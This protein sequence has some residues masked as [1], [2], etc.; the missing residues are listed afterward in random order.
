MKRMVRRSIALAVVFVFATASVAFAAVSWGSRVTLPGNYAW[1]YSNSLDYTGTPGTGS[2]KLHEAFVSDATLP[3]AVKYTS[4][5]NGTA[6]S[7]PKKVSGPQHAEGSSL[8]SAGSTVI[9][10]WMTGFSSYDPAGAARRLQVNVSQDSGATWSGVQ[11]LTAATGKVDYPIVAAA[12]TSG[13]ATNVYAAWVNA[14]NGKVMF[15]QSTN[16][17][18]WAAPI[19]LG[20]TTAKDTATTYYGYANV[21][22]VDDLIAVVW[23]ADDTGTLKVRSIDLGGN[24]AAANTLTNWNA[25]TTLTDKISLAHNGYPIAS[26]S[27]Q[28]TGVV[29]IAYNTATAQ[30]YTKF[31]GTTVTAAGTTI[32]THASPYTGGYSTA[33]EPAPGGGYVAMWGGCRNTGIANPCNYGSTKAR[34]DLLAS[35]SANGTTWSAPAVVE[36]ASNAQHLNDEASMVVI[37]D[38]SGVKIFAQYNTYKAT[39][40]YYDVWMRIATGSL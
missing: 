30:K 18:A 34:F 20:A 19:T 14:K 32:Y 39:Y 37:P 15:R 23:V 36:A 27:P 12:K 1:N 6:W 4:S 35:T 38:A 22:A 7:K 8:A 3:E 28:N 17:G 16:G 29:T 9:V 26:A 13:G 31:N 11:N 40:T 10:G 21:A 33:V 5:A 2:F 24:A 25:A